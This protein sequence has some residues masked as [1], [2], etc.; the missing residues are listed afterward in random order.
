LAHDDPSAYAYFPSTLPDADSSR[1]AVESYARVWGRHQPQEAAAWV[2]ERVPDD[3][4]DPAAAG[5]L[6]GWLG[7]DYDAATEWLADQRPSAEIDAA[8]AGY[9][10][11]LQRRSPEKA[12]D[13]ALQISDEPKRN[14]IITSIAER[15]QR[16]DPE[17][18][19]QYFNP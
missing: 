19:A 12:I 7:R 18:A 10:S 14:Q 3:L 5:V 2:D 9:S 4:R 17:A 13:L 16:H 15:W 11:R 8:I 6:Q 1:R